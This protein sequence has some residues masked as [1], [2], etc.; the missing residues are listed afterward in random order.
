MAAQDDRRQPLWVSVGLSLCA[1]L[2]PAISVLGSC[3]RETGATDMIV[4]DSGRDDH[5]VLP[6]PTTV[7]QPR[8]AVAGDPQVLANS[9]DPEALVD[10]AAAMAASPSSAYH[11]ELSKYLAQAQFLDRLDDPAALP[12]T[13]QLLKLARV[14]WAL[15]GNE[16]DS[17]RAVLVGLIDSPEYQAHPYRMELLVGALAT[18]RPAPPSVLAY[19]SAMIVPDHPFDVTAL[20]AAIE[21]GSTSALAMVEDK[22]RDPAIAPETKVRWLRAVVV[23]GRT[24]PS[25]LAFCDRLLRSSV[26]SVV[27][28]GMVEAL[29][30]YDPD[31][32]FP[33]HTY[34]P[35]DLGSVDAETRAQLRAIARQALKNLPLPSDLEARLHP[36]AASD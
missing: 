28:V 3:I 18:V 22:F 29:F 20:S 5:I 34:S 25:M 2:F 11:R 19:W 12:G 8:A 23:P 14:I 16:A 36:F 32:F 7:P 10:A 33:D 30:S 31:W 35:P 26:P 4:D 9:R 21:N 24:D 27:A 15:M 17:A 13:P 1:A 6:T